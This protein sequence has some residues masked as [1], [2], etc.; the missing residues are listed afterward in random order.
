MLKEIISAYGASIISAILTAIMGA[1]AIAIK[2]LYKQ[3]INTDIKTALANTVVMFVEQV[4]T[5]LHGAD[6][7]HEAMSVLADRL[8]EYN[9]KISEEEMEMLIEAAVAEF[10]AFRLDID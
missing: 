4:Y 6:K 8:S 10:N 7:L 9:I 1:F 5:D 2:R 3:Y